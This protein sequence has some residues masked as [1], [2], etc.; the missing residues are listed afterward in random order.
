MLQRDGVGTMT[1]PECEPQG[2]WREE[3]GKAN[4]DESELG[5]ERDDGRL[6]RNY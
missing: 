2:I 5:Y 4:S 6:N 1:W 3:R